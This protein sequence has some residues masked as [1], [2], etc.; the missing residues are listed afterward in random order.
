MSRLPKAGVYF[1]YGQNFSDRESGLRG[2]N[3]MAKLL[4]KLHQEYPTFAA[5]LGLSNVD[6]ESAERINMR[7]G[8]VGRPQIGF[9]KKPGVKKSIWKK[10]H[11]HIVIVGEY[12][13]TVAKKF[14]EIMSKRYES[15]KDSKHLKGNAFIDE[16]A[17]WDGYYS[18]LYF[19]NQAQNCLLIDEKELLAKYDRN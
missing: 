3:N 17:K 8:K 1:A 7:Q 2:L 4:K 14:C 18:M 5:Y 16:K 19:T 6:G 10:Y 13:A 9:Q 12:S 11:I 15:E